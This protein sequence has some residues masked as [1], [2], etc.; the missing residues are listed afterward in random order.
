MRLPALPG[1]IAGQSALSCLSQR[2]EPASWN[3][4][5]GPHSACT[6]WSWARMCMPATVTT[7]RSWPAEVIRATTAAVTDRLLRELSAH[8]GLP[9]VERL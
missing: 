3:V 1:T 7:T 8:D 5:G 4:P 9:R 6:P 2:P